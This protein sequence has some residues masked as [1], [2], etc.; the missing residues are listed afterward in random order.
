ML[1]GQLAI[2]S[3][4]CHFCKNGCYCCC[5]VTLVDLKTNRWLA[6][7][8]MSYSHCELIPDW[9]NINWTCWTTSVFCMFLCEWMRMIM[10]IVRYISA[11]VKCMKW[12]FL[13]KRNVI[14]AWKYFC[15]MHATSALCETTF[16]SSNVCDS[17]HFSTVSRWCSSKS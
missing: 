4:W 13:H 14:S 10:M 7:I 16:Q 11:L 17:Y 5:D 6:D 2:N 3:W 9:L 8:I 1:F 15:F 12:I